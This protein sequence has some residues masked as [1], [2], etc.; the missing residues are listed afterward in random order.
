VSR[1]RRWRSFIECSGVG[2]SNVDTA[3]AVALR[4]TRG[5]RHLMVDRFIGAGNLFVPMRGD[6]MIFG[7]LGRDVSP[8]LFDGQTAMFVVPAAPEQPVGQHRRG[9]QKGK[10][11]PEH[12]HRSGGTQQVSLSEAYGQ[13]PNESIAIVGPCSVLNDCN[14]N[15]GCGYSKFASESAWIERICNWLFGQPTWLATPCG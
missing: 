11:N 5:I 2:S 7:M 1:D 13:S 14:G 10:E 8:Y 6:V 4:R 3:L 9:R 12:Q 15:S